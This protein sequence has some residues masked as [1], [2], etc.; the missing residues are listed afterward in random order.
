MIRSVKGRHAAALIPILAAALWFTVTGTAQQAAKP[1]AAKPEEAKPAETANQ[2]ATYTGS[3]MCAACHEDI[4]N[5]FKKSPHFVVEREKKRGWDGKAC[6]S[7][8]GPA[9]KHAES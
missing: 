4:S 5:A 1:E 3:E 8:H 9:S 6:E 7:C 2:P